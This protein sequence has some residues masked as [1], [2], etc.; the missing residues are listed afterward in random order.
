MEIR[1]AVLEKMGAPAPYAIS[2]PLH[3][4][5]IE[6][7]GPGPGEVLVRIA[8]AG[9]CHSDLSVIEGVRPR[10]LPMVIGH[11]SS[12]VVE[13]V[14]PYVYDFAPGDHVVTVFVAA[15]GHCVPCS[16]GRPALCEPG[17]AAG[18][19][20]TLLRGARR[21]SAEGD[22][23]NHH[24]GVSC[25]AEYAT[26]SARS[27]VKIDSSI[28]LESAALFGCAV[29]TGVG[30]AINTARIQLGQTVVIVGMGGVGL[31]ALLGAYAAGAAQVI[32]VDTNPDKLDK[33]R[34][35]GAT[36]TFNA[37]DED[38]VQQIRDWNH[39]GADVALEFAGAA[40]A[41]DLAWRVAK[42]GGEVVTAGLAPPTATFAVPMVAL[43]AEERSLRGSYM[44]SSVPSRDIP[45]YL[46]LFKQGRLPV[47]QLV[48][49]RLSLDE[50]NIGM[51]RLKDGSAIRQLITF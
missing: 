46:E 9:I 23:L 27:L 38:V 34:S 39:G 22:A 51:D 43:V 40:P 44:G 1:A 26:V 3:I 41:L 8:A 21:L 17:S 5:H 30:A 4:Q 7:E 24:S 33:A 25:F 14:G 18:A 45:R 15:C 11:E 13:A 42:R 20:G 29:L 37:R 49:H 28:A 6:L 50:V 48:T 16:G 2:K 31:A 32:A 10:P 47:D 12:G 19:A 36:A 35:L